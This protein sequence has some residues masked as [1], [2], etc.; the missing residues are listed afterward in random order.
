MA[1][2]RTY[3]VASDGTLVAELTS[4]IAQ[5]KDTEWQA[6]CTKMLQRIKDSN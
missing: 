6:I 4:K 3:K 1:R 2:S 5:M